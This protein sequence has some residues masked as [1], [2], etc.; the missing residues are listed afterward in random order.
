MVL[1]TLVAGTRAGRQE[2]PLASRRADDQ[3][4]RSPLCVVCG[5]AKES[6]GPSPLL[7]RTGFSAPRAGTRHL[8]DDPSPRAAADSGAPLPGTT[9]GGVVKCTRMRGVG[10][11]KNRPAARGRVGFVSTLTARIGFP[12]QF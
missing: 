2:S 3:L 11:V 9:P 4:G 10:G 6:R 5:Q 12:P 8:D 1:D 7:W